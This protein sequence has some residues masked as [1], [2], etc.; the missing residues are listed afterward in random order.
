MYPQVPVVVPHP[1][2]D[3][4]AQVSHR[5]LHPLKRRHQSREGVVDDIFGQGE[6]PAQG[7][8]EPD[9][10]SPVS[11]V[12]VVEV[13]PTDLQVRRFVSP[14]PFEHCPL[15]DEQAPNVASPGAERRAVLEAPGFLSRSAC[16]SQA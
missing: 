11:L 14:Y 6:G 5:V 1:V 16:L 9:Q 2:E 15:D 8:T 12:E 4:L 10:A 13:H 3:C 7:V